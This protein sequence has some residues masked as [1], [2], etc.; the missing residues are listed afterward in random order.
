MGFNLGFKGLI[1]RNKTAYNF[2]V[3][4]RG[5][6][7]RVDRMSLTPRKNGVWECCDEEDIWA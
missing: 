2:A 3:I 6:E 1:N 5:Y 4:L 7:G